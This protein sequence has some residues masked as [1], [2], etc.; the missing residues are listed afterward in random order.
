M[1]ETRKL[2][3]LIRDGAAK[4]EQC[5]KMYFTGNCHHA[6]AIGA[7]LLALYTPD[8][9]D[10]MWDWKLESLDDLLTMPVTG[11]VKHPVLGDEYEGVD[12]MW[13]VIISL[14]DDHNWSRERIA[15]WL[16][17]EGY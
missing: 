13:V 8:E 2:S 11:K 4:T 16:E 12:S 1:A 15:D 10:E 9:I 6:C 14:N 3:A 17:S 5:R 7:A